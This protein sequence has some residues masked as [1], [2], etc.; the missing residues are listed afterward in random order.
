[1]YVADNCAGMTLEHLKKALQ[2]GE[3]AS[4]ESR[5][6]EHGFGLKNALATLSGGNGPWKIWTKSSSCPQVSSVEVPFR[7]E[8]AVND[9]DAFPT[10]NFLPPDLGTLIKV[11]VKRNFIQSVQGRDHPEGLIKSGATLAGVV[12]AGLPRHSALVAA[13]FRH[14]VAS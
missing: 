7:S 10:D 8:M 2:L 12:A 5:L 4:T 13:A 14:R 3:S 6:N 1:M 11:P 9:S